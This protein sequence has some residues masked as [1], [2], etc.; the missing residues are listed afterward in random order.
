MINV[1]IKNCNNIDETNININENCLNIKYAINWTWKSS[2]AKAIKYYLNDKNNLKD[3]IPFKRI[4]TDIIPEVTWVD[5]FKKVMIFDE[6]YINQYT[7]EWGQIHKDS[8]EIFINWE[9]Y[10]EW[11]EEI[12]KLTENTRNTFNE[13][14]DINN[15][16]DDLEKLIKFYG[17]SKKPSK[18][19]VLMKWIWK[20]NNFHNIPEWLDSYSDY[21]K[22]KNINWM[23][24]Q[25]EWK[26]FLNI[27]EDNCPY[28]ISLIQDKKETILKLSEEY[29][30]KDIENLKKFLEVIDSLN[31]YF[32][33]IVQDNIKDIINNIDWLNEDHIKYIENIKDEAII[34][35]NKLL[36]LKNINFFHLKDAEKIDEEIEKSK[37]NLNYCNYFISDFSKEK[38][39]IIDDTLDEL[40]IN[41]W[42][43]IWAINKQKK[44][45]KRTIDKYKIEMN[46]FLLS[47]WYKYEI[48]SI[49]D[50]KSYKLILK[51][52]GWTESLNWKDHLSYWERN[53]LSLVLF[54]YQCLS[55]KADFIIFDDPISSFDKNK[56]FAILNMFFN[57]YNVEWEAKWEN[58]RWKTILMLTHDFDPVID[59]IYNNLKNL[60]LEWKTAYFLENK[61]WILVE[62]EIKKENI[63][64]FW[65]ILKEN[66]KSDNLVNIVYLRRFY[67]INAERWIEY[68]LLSNLIHK[69]EIPTKK[70]E[71]DIN[72]LDINNIKKKV[73]EKDNE[74]LEKIYLFLDNFNSKDKSDE[75]IKKIS[76]YKEKIPEIEIINATTN[77]KDKLNNF[78]YFEYL[79]KLNNLELMLKLY[80]DSTSN[81]EKLQIYRIINDWKS[82]ESAVVMKFINETFHIENDYLFQLNPREYEI[83][84]NY[85]I[86]ECDR[87]LLLSKN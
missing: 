84:P 19:W 76:K 87:D 30:K 31:I 37:V 23:S 43:L 32:P 72:N 20:W 38:I 17:N 45:V 8:F 61:S 67:E 56:K 74:K 34:I 10:K 66:T 3:L 82:H 39:K 11:M 33:K 73:F 12:N 15:F 41:I 5:N 83:I 78:D 54:M 55:E 71:I 35:K 60:D 70:L 51:H 68:Q 85:I 28:C 65:E 79:E 21:I 63:K 77:I 53:A 48:D 59:I 16:I 24:W 2:I 36:K 49:E 4:W 26:S 80:K 58:L 9:E 42:K 13:N 62:K 29:D 22:S 69:R 44:L 86:E 50:G 47:A 52:I 7:F 64:S 40:G 6:E 81:Y 25:L 14:E 75:N 57:G 46:Y 1:K 27:K 18:A